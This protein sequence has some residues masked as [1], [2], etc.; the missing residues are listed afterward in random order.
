M[1]Q[2]I[3][4]DIK[5]FIDDHFGGVVPL[6]EAQSEWGSAQIH[7]WRQ[8][9]SLPG[10]DLAMLLG[11]LEARDGAPVSVQPY[12]SGDTCVISL[13]Q[14]PVTTGHTPSVFD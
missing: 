13:K 12:L 9:N 14:K 1:G 3:T 7:K 11:I 5:R 10:L 8:R 2:Q 4:F 6:C